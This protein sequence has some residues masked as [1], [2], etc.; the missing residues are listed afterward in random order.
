MTY[1][2]PSHR[3][4]TFNNFSSYINLINWQN[5]QLYQRI[6]WSSL[7][8]AKK[9]FIFVIKRYVIRI[10][11]DFLSVISRLTMIE[12]FFQSEKQPNSPNFKLVEAHYSNQVEVVAR[13]LEEIGS[14]KL[15]LL[16]A[17]M[18]GLDRFANSFVTL[19]KSIKK[20]EPEIELWR[21]PI[22]AF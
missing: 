19:S 16:L 7:F 1:L 4:T 17:V 18:S 2:L 12:E 5:R 13:K 20:P 14:K 10:L 9:R 15:S 21:A 6:P 22:Q 11:H 3:R 8:A